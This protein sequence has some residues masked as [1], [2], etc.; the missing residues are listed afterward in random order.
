MDVP[1]PQ[2]KQFSAFVANHDCSDR[3][4][5]LT[6]VLDSSAIANFVGY[7]GARLSE[8]SCSDVDMFA[9]TVACEFELPPFSAN[10]GILFKGGFNPV[11]YTTEW[12]GEETWVNSFNWWW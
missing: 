9:G 7:T 2:N 4:L 6:V 12:V 3:K 5:L 1:F 8:K 11:F 10:L